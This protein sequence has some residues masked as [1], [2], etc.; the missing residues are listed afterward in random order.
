[1]EDTTILSQI[2]SLVDEEHKLREQLAAGEITAGEEHDRLRAVEESLDQC[3]DL[4][5]RRRA[6][7]EFGQDPDAQEAHS[8]QEVENYLQ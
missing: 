1:M 2:N 5:R 8:K 6:A 3:W 7:R 4:L